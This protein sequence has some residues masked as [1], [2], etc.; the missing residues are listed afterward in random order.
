MSENKLMIAAAGSGKTTHLVAEAKKVKDAQVLITTYTEANDLE[1]RKKFKAIPSNITIQT[2]F[3][4]LLE[5]GVRPYQSFILVKKIK[6]MILVNSASG[7][8]Y[9][10]RQGFSVGY[11][12]ESETEKHYLSTDDRIYSDKISKFV[13]NC[14]KKSD[15]AVLKRL[16]QIYTHIYIDEVQDLA[17]YDLE[18]IRLMMKQGINVSLVGDPRQVTYLTHH[19]KKYPKYKDGKIKEFI[20]NE[21]PKKIPCQIDE[22]TLSVSHRNNQEICDLSS[23]LYPDFTAISPCECS[24]CVDSRTVPNRGLYFVRP[25]HVECYLAENQVIQLRW[26]KRVE[27]SISAAAINFGNS[28][29]LGFEHVLIYPTQ[30]MHDWLIDSNAQLST[31]ARAK[32]Y[33]AITRAMHSVAFVSDLDSVDFQTFIPISLSTRKVGT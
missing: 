30:D 1:I 8:K 23:K 24:K 16:A 10:N 11:D 25:E 20:L 15:G 6:G 3:S 28:K 19:P 22:T 18:L 7:V 5:H 21:L 26:D 14:N 31:E 13:C 2:W 4:F 27:T 32:L 12:E 9:I 33:V 29:G 17:G